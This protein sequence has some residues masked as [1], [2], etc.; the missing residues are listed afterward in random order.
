MLHLR[1]VIKPSIETQ[2]LSIKSKFDHKPPNRKEI[3]LFL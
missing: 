2:L 3:F 1:F